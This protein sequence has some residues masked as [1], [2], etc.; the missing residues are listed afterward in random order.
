MSP[1]D[2]SR[3]RS[4]R[5]IDVERAVGMGS[6]PLRSGLD[7]KINAVEEAIHSAVRTH[8]RGRYQNRPREVTG[9]AVLREAPRIRTVSGTYEAQ[10]KV[11]IHV[12]EVRE[13]RIF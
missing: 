4:W 11:F 3:L 1:A 10:V 5:R 7:G 9:T 8:L 6:A 13:Y 2:H 12:T